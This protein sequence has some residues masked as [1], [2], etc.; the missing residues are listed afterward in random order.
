MGS[1][2][3]R[4]KQKSKKPLKSDE[5]LAQRSVIPAVDSRKRPKSNVTDG[6][7]EP[8]TKRPRSDWVTH[9][10][11]VRLKKVAKEGNP[12]TK[13]V[14][15]PVSYDPWA[16]DATPSNDKESEFSFLPKPKPLVAPPTLGHSPLSLAANGKAIPSVGNPDPGASYNPS[17]EDWDKLL[18][19]E[20]EKEV[21][22]EKQRLEELRVEQERLARVT[23]ADGNN[24]DA[25]GSDD[26]SAWEGFESEYENSEALSKK[27][28]ERKTQA[29]R[30]KIKRRKEAE[31]R[32]KWEAQMKKREEQAAEAKAISKAIKDK[33]G[34]KTKSQ[35]KDSD[36]SEEGDDAS[37]RRRRFG[38]SQ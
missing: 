23:E 34:S 18:T 12:E 14:Q 37:L 3:V 28:P 24:D 15:G 8:K 30:N 31:R 27:R 29:Q 10:E 36:S 35:Q 5:I 4:R 16:D 17:F 13:G 32:A 25:A 9:A 38:K 2:E 6:I 7:V 11:W 22:A 21:E 20:G 33:D 19:K 1:E 26:E